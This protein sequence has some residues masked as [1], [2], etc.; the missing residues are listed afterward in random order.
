MNELI[1][2]FQKLD[3]DV[4]DEQ[5]NLYTTEEF[6]K[7]EL[8]KNLLILK[9]I[10]N[11][12]FSK[13]FNEEKEK[14]KS[15]LKKQLDDLKKNVNNTLK[16]IDKSSYS[17]SE[18]DDLLNDLGIIDEDF[19]NY[20]EPVKKKPVKKVKK[21]PVKKTTLKA[22][23][24]EF[25][26]L[27]SGMKGK[28]KALDREQSYTKPNN[29][30]IE[31]LKNEMKEMV[32]QYKEKQELIKQMELEKQPKKSKIPEIPSELPQWILE[33]EFGPARKAPMRP[34]KLDRTL[35]GKIIKP[36]IA[37]IKEIKL[38]KCNMKKLNLPC[39]FKNKKFNTFNELL[40]FIQNKIKETK[41]RKTK[42][43][44]TK[45]FEELKTQYLEELNKQIKKNK[46]YRKDNK[47]LE[48]RKPTDTELDEILPKEVYLPRFRN[49]V[50]RKKNIPNLNEGWSYKRPEKKVKKRKENSLFKDIESFLEEDKKE[51]EEEDKKEQIK[52][53][54]KEIKKN[55][56]KSI[57]TNK[58]MA[59]PWIEHVRKCRAEHPEWTY[60]KALSECSKTYKSTKKPKSDSKQLKQTLKFLNERER[61][62]K[63]RSKKSK[64]NVDELLEEELPPLP[65]TAAPKYHV[66]GVYYPYPDIPAPA[67]PKKLKN[68]SNK[69]KKF[70]DK[71]DK[72]NKKIE[73]NIL[74]FSKRL[75]NLKD[76]KKKQ[77][78]K[79]KI[80]SFMNKYK[81]MKKNDE[82]KNKKIQDNI[83]KFTSRLESMKKKEQ[84]KT[85]PKPKPKEE[86]YDL[87]KGRKPPKPKPKIKSPLLGLNDKPKKIIIP[88]NLNDLLK[89][90]LYKLN[91]ENLCKVRK[92]FYELFQN[93]NYKKMLKSD[94]YYI[95]EWIKE[96][97]TPPNTK[98]GLIEKFENDI[99]S[100]N[101]AI[102]NNKLN[103]FLKE[104]PDSKQQKRTIIIN[105]W[106]CVTTDRWNEIKEQSN[107]YEY[108]SD[109]KKFNKVVFDGKPT[110][111]QILKNLNLSKNDII[112]TVEIYKELPKQNFFSCDTKYNKDIIKKG[113]YKGG[114]DY[115]EDITFNLI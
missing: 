23:K 54:S 20:F 73:D 33:Q 101:T 13:S 7:D 56:N 111:N 28:K 90:K 86:P 41:N 34:E 8:K 105:V 16:I 42:Q 107:L 64:I 32:K 46:K 69:I 65:K 17:L 104:C 10:I 67:I 30:K 19:I 110:L 6:N 106:R 45:K 25:S 2:Y 44:L 38:K 51:K 91:Q 31:K 66:D 75:K 50:S 68:L 62:I 5:V 35:K 58:K 47:K 96:G 21:K 99:K 112:D 109:N 52:E 1:K 29:N 24:K 88:N 49:F 95:Y 48:L 40:K 3:D 93:I 27:L 72:K 36:E 4:Q 22:Q 77:Q 37:E 9:D 81:D 115:T 103:N 53:E 76:E 60:K 79:N 57:D 98:K 43:G 12:K 39:E 100:F 82:M 61:R 63:N 87:S 84:P 78:M 14:F 108:S 15:L 94:L 114:I 74:K 85:E 97:A 80:K 18:S 83:K 113:L 26:L 102:K 92:K 71:Q 59:N 70:I 89:L 11:S 55:N